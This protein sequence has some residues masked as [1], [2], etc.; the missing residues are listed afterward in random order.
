MQMWVY[1]VRRVLLVVP[2][3]IGVM[4]I[5]FTLVSAVPT[6]QRISSYFPA[7][8]HSNPSTPTVPCPDD[9]SK[10][11]PN[12]AYE[13]A[14]AY[15]QLNQP[16]PVQWAWYMYNALTFQWGYVSQTSELGNGEAGLPALRGQSVT[17]V[18]GTFLPYTIELALLSLFFILLLAIPVGRL[19]AAYRNRPI[20]Q[21]ARVM[22]FSGYALP[23]FILGTFVLAGVAALLAHG[24]TNS[25]ICS[26]GTA[27][28][29]FY[30]SWPVPHCWI[31]GGGLSTVGYPSWLVSGY[32]STPTGFPTIDSLIH[33]NGWLAL[34]T[35]LRLLLPALV[36]A[37]GTTA[38]L[39][40]FVRNST[41]EVMNLDYVRTARAKGLPDSVVIRKHAGR[42]S[43]NATVTVLGLTFATFL[44]GFPVIETVF[45]L[46]GVGRI[47]AL[48]LVNSAGTYDFAVIF[49]TTILFTYMVVFAN[50]I[51]DVLY[52][53][54]DPRVRL[55]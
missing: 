7:N 5:T 21:L 38:T 16:V 39:L 12:K 13:D 46:Y 47:F 55:G 17:S 36:I 8:P 10:Q 40:R 15:L 35:L 9:P 18:L 42:T 33:G 34:D 22:S 53:H 43:L 14:V 50:I 26:T 19:A 23:G 27:F 2:V 24:G 48:A 52:A 31:W 29:E 25:P 32:Q 49:G 51:V 4:T 45:S 11:C 44:A 54:L 37:Y 3:I 1:V 41:L 20:D 28:L 30:G 6:S